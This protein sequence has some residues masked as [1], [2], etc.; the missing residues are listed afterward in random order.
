MPRGSYASRAL[1]RPAALVYVLPLAAAPLLLAPEAPEPVAICAPAI[2]LEPAAEA[3]ATLPRLHSLVVSWR[4]DIVFERYFRGAGP[5]RHANVKSV[6]KSVISALVGIAIDRGLL[7]GADAPIGPFFPELRAPGADPA[8]AA[9]RIEDLLT[10]RSGLVP[11]SN[12]NYGAWTASPNWVSYILSR[13]LHGEPGVERSYS[14]GNS[15]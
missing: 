12:R 1:R 7:S 14:T 13:P 5:A 2:G 3:A 6:S 15:H 8:K 11:T 9:I 4:G 10:M